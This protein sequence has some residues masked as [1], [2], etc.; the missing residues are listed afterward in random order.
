[1]SFI[2]GR[3]RT[4]N[5]W[6]PPLATG[7]N[8]KLTK[9]VGGGGGG[10]GGLHPIPVKPKL[11]HQL[12]MDLSTWD[13]STQQVY[14]HIDWL[15]FEV[16]RSSTTPIEA[17]WWC[18][19]IHLAFACCPCNYWTA[20]HHYYKF[21]NLSIQVICRFGSPE[22]LITDQG[23]E[24]VNEL[25]DEL[26]SITQTNHRIT[27]AYH[28]QVIYSIIT[29]HDTMLILHN[30]THPLQTNGLTERFNQTLSQC[31]AKVCN[32][33]HTNW[34]E[35]LDTV[36]MASCQA[37]TKHS[38]YYMLFQ[39]HM[40]LPIDAEVLPPSSAP[41]ESDKDALDMDTAV[42]ALIESRERVFKKAESNIS[43][44]QKR[45]KETYDRK[46]QPEEIVEG[47]QVL[48][49]NTAQKQRKGVQIRARMAWAL[50]RQPVHW[51]RAVRVKQRWEGGK[52]ESKY[53]STEG[54]QE[55]GWWRWHA[56]Y[57]SFNKE[58]QGT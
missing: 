22:T 24:F 2:I 41:D 40:R 46:H 47:T 56:G 44:A 8:K 27:S 11:F 52:E 33:D 7:L 21:C 26:Y 19:Q 17:C 3:N 34:D 58:E 9:A 30:V 31:L 14:S 45:Q 10:G 18:C 48:L 51:K 55:E 36:L 4:T 1:M 49:E 37:S 5:S 50:Y 43:S 13:T 53:S 12:G 6:P 38:P 29:L 57:G 35:K 42:Q 32:E 15:F 23:R 28:P 16:G 54:V 39:Q 20:I 25:S